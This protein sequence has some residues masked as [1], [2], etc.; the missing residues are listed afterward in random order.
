MQMKAKCMIY[1]TGDINW[2]HKKN[3]GPAEVICSMW[4]SYNSPLNQG[5]AT[6]GPGMAV[7]WS[8]QLF[9]NMKGKYG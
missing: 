2:I 1:R 3:M 4:K 5:Y 6:K 9:L 7:H 8:R